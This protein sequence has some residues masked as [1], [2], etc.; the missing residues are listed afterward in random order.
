MANKATHVVCHKSLYLRVNGKMQ[1]MK[2]GE[3]LTLSKDQAEKLVAKGFVKPVSAKE[4][5]TAGKKQNDK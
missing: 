4:P 3:E 5:A 2:E 1:E